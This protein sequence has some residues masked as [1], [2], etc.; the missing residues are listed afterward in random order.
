MI[1]E[2]IKKIA[3]ANGWIGILQK[4]REELTEALEAVNEYSDGPGDEKEEQHLI[5]ELVDVVIVADQFALK[6]RRQ[7]DF[8]R[9][10]EFKL[11]R[12]ME[13]LGLK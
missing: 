7:A 2:R 6:F 3:A 8:E 11:E 13:R 10:R 9:W 12:T 4:L 1:D 5:E